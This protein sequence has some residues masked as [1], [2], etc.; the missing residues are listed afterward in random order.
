[1]PKKH[2]RDR[3]EPAPDLV[4]PTPEEQKELAMMADP[5]MAEELEAPAPPHSLTQMLDNIR[6]DAKATR[7]NTAQ[8]ISELEAMRAEI[9]AA[10]AFLRAGRR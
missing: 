9:D 8:T 1:M 6:A 3:R 5:S 7:H 2:K 10:I 4:Q